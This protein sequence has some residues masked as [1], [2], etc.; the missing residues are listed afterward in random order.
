MSLSELLQMSFVQKALI[1]GLILSTITAICG[2]FVVLK[3]E[4]FLTDAIAHVSM[5]GVGIGLLAGI[6]PLFGAILIALLFSIAFTFIKHKTINANDSLIGILYSFFFAIGLI[7]IS[8]SRGIRVD[9]ESFLFGSLYSISW[10]EILI[11]GILLIVMII[12]LSIKYQDLVFSVFDTEGAFLKG[13]KTKKLEYLSNILLSIAII[14]GIKS[15]GL[16]LVTALILA[17]ANT[18]INLSKK[19]NQVIPLAILISIITN[20]IGILLSLIFNTP[21]GPTI[22]ITASIAYFLS[23]G[24]KYL[25]DMPRK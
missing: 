20:T 21:A 23:V 5:A 16:I 3:K 22:V 14:V 15:V 9:L 17:P 6:Y 10:E 25:F 24:R 2:V 13:I 18:S 1:G 7:M 12:F 11:S 4:A 8:L 19:F